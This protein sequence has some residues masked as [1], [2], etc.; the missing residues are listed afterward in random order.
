MPDIFGQRVAQF[1]R[2]SEG[3]QAV[4][5]M[6]LM[7]P[8][9][10]LLVFGVAELTQAYTVGITISASTREG[11]RIA[12]AL[13]NGGGNLGC[14]GSNSPNAATVDPQII[15]A[16]ERVLT[17][18]G[19][20]INLADVGEIRIYKSDSVGNEVSGT[21]NRFTYS[22]NGGSTVDGQQLDFVAA[23]SGWPA[24]SRTNVTPADP[25]GVSMTYTYRAR[26]PLKWLVPG[27]ATIAISDRSVMD[28]NATR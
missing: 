5:E 2:S 9:L 28:L 27:L 15:A 8:L 12:G 20:S 3:G 22:L 26:T 1:L 14:G 23:T 7:L 10:L 18:S 16:I 13:V 21:S 6:A 17:A 24:C 11:A 4:V 25:A 19:T